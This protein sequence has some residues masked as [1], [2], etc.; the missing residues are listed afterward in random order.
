MRYQANIAEHLGRAV[1]QRLEEGIDRLSQRRQVI[2]LPVQVDH[3]LL[4]LAPELLDRIAPGRL[5]RQ[6]HQLDR[7]PQVIPTRDRLRMGF[8][9]PI[10]RA[11]G[12]E[13]QFLRLQRDQHIRMAME[14]PVTLDQIDPLGLGVAGHH[15]LV[16]GHQVGHP[17]PGR[18]VGKDATRARIEGGSRAGHDRLAARIPVG[19]G[20]LTADRRPGL[21]LARLAQDARLILVEGHDGVVGLGRGEAIIVNRQLGRIIGIGTVEREAAPL[22]MQ[23]VSSEQPPAPGEALAG[24]T[25]LDLAEGGGFSPARCRLAESCG[26]PPLTTMSLQRIA[27]TLPTKRAS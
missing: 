8:A 14:R 24:R 27:P 6:R 13:G 25:G 9:R 12:R 5:G 4:E 3:L 20:L 2:G 16:A 11:V 1:L 17:N 19:Q 21:S 7:Q 15:L 23:S 18:A 26:V 22:P 10:G